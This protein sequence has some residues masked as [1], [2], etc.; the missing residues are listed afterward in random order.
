MMQ[1]FVVLQFQSLHPIKLEWSAICV[2]MC[3]MYMMPVPSHSTRNKL[4]LPTLNLCPPFVKMG[5]C[6]F[7]K[8][9]GKRMISN[10]RKAL[11]VWTDI[12]NI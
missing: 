11:H 3:Q 1:S 2:V 5:L 7:Q 8:V 4:S 12:K 10:V 6:E 9:T